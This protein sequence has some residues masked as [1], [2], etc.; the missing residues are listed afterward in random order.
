MLWVLKITVSIRR[1]FRAPKHISKL[2]DEKNINILRK[3]NVYLDLFACY[4][5]NCIV[6][7]GLFQNLLLTILTILTLPVSGGINIEF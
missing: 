4:N 6:F 3:Q 2:M 5:G 7:R 1:L